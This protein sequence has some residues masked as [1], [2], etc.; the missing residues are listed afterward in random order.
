MLNDSLAPIGRAFAFFG[1]M[2]AVIGALT[3]G[4]DVQGSADQSSATI[5][6]LKQRQNLPAETEFA[7]V[8]PAHRTADRTK[9]AIATSQEAHLA[10][11]DRAILR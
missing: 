2:A 10:N 11:P 6:Q 3:L 9:R 1:I 4:A 8:D 5:A 7:S